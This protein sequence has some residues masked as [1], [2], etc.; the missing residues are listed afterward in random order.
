[1]RPAA[2]P[3]AAL[4]VLEAAS[5]AVMS[6]LHLTSAL[7]GGSKPYDPTDAGIAEAIIC[8]V[9]VAGATALIRG[10]PE[11]RAIA[12]GSVMFAILGFVV[13]LTLTVRGG[14]A[15]DIAYHATV[16][17]LLLVTARLLAVGPK[18]RWA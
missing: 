2:K 13:G 16:L 10:V 11:A 7:A 18:A 1:M 4:M 6:S 15:V 3:V 14:S 5:L 17:P 12:L 8:L 9:L